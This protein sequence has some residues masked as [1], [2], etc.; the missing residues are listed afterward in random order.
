M[1][2]FLFFQHVSFN[3]FFLLVFA[4]YAG[5]EFMLIS[6]VVIRFILSP[7]LSLFITLFISLHLAL[8]P[9]YLILFLLF[10]SLIHFIPFICAVIESTSPRIWKAAV[11][12]FGPD[13]VILLNISFFRL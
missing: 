12:N 9:I 5:S 4:S 7:I 6:L 3:F 13:T 8:F 2:I 10:L 1:V 11:A